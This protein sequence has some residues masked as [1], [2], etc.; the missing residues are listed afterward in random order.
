MT[1]PIPFD[2]R[3]VRTWANINVAA[4]SANVQ[5]LSRFVAPGELMAVVKAD[6]YGHGAV[7][8]ARVCA[9]NGVGHFGVATVEEAL[10]L[11][12]AGVRGDIYLLSSFHLPEAEAIVRGDIIPMLSS[13]VHFA[14]IADAAQNAPLPARAFLVVDTGM[15]REGMSPEEARSVWNAAESGKSNVVLTGITSH[16]AC[17]DDAEPDGTTATRAQTRSF[18][19]FVRSVAEAFPGTDDGRGV[20]GVSLSTF[21]SPGSIRQA[22]WEPTPANLPG[23]RGVLHRAGLSLYGIEPFAGAF[24][25][26]PNLQQILTWQARVV[27][28]RD[29]PEGATVGYGRTHTLARPSRIA[30]V[31]CGY[32]DGYPRR[33]SNL[34]TVR[35][36]GETFPVV[37]RVSMDQMQVDIS[38]ATE[39]VALGDTVT[40]LGDDL[41]TL[42]FAESIGATAH[43]PTCYLTNRVPRL[44]MNI[45]TVP[46]TGK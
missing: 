2:P 26:L 5:T 11:R 12:K 9:Q 3:T 27:L 32:A 28:I 16:L 39:P 31:A 23:V 13:P 45:P 33:L 41:P 34:G 37:G 29:L 1:R 35:L 22:E 4:L 19:A 40:L 42:T 18:A 46:P 8:V 43:E 15:G 36:R 20:A 6:A 14:A 10:T 7:P 21:N 30:T 44:Y 25:C 17:A 24:A 38:G